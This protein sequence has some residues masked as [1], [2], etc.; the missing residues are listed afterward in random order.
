[1]VVMTRSCT[2]RLPET[3]LCKFALRATIFADLYGCMTGIVPESPIVLTPHTAIDDALVILVRID[4][5]AI[6][7][8]ILLTLGIVQRN[9]LYIHLPRDRVT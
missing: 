5:C 1:M 3:E 2:A 7:T 6:R 9:A 4:I 8:K